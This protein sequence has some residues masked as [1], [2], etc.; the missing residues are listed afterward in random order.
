M[1]GVKSARPRPDLVTTYVVLVIGLLLLA[2]IWLLAA[3]RGSPVD[4]SHDPAAA[5]SILALAAALA[6]GVE[7][8]L[9]V[10]WTV[11]DQV[12]KNPWYPFSSQAESLD[13]FANRVRDITKPALDQAQRAA[14]ELK[15]RGGTAPA[16]LA[17]LDKQ[18]ADLQA[19]VR[20]KLDAKDPKVAGGLQSLQTALDEMARNLASTD[21]A[22]VLGAAV[23]GLDAL[24]N[25]LTSISS[26]PNP[27]RRIMSLFLG[28]YIGLAAAWIFGID[29]IHA[30]LGTHD[31][32]GQVHWALAVTGVVIG[33]GSVPLHELISA[34]QAFRNA[35]PAP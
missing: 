1:A 35:Q 5:A 24:D 19:N 14:D 8:S 23:A 26:D 12:A 28:S 2:A 15:T 34:V 29:V 18:I 33:F 17:V 31:S 10:M 7:R 21:A 11:V 32:S 13:D 22:P 9:E 27:G 3:F 25:Y 20:A 6:V 4:T 16:D 30:A